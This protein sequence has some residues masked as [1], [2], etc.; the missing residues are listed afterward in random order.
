MRIICFAEFSLDTESG[1]LKK[2][3]RRVRLPNKPFLVLASL[4]ERPG[5]LVTRKEL[6]ERLWPDTVVDF[7]HSLDSVIQKLRSV[8]G[9]SGA[10]T[11]QAGWAVLRLRSDSPASIST[12]SRSRVEK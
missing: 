5:T 2:L 6:I 1:E 3:D 10:G 11:A 9:D 7:E 8:L 12:T 4:L